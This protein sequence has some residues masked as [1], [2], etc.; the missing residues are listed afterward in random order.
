MSLSGQRCPRAHRRAGAG[1]GVARGNR[2]WLQKRDSNFGSEV[3][4]DS[5][6]AQQHSAHQR[7]KYT[8][9]QRPD[10]SGCTLGLSWW[11]RSQH[12]SEP[13][14]AVQL[15]GLTQQ[16]LQPCSGLAGLGAVLQPRRGC[17]LCAH[18][19][20]AREDE[21]GA[22]CR[23]LQVP[24]PCSVPALMVQ[25]QQVTVSCCSAAAPFQGLPGGQTPCH[26]CHKKT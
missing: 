26:L 16:P 21:P 8:Y 1:S 2:K 13:S 4:R 12:S 3:Q 7:C 11:D 17:G 10:T 9:L 19:G 20:A 22:R 23:S 24:V 18:S 6:A 5:H 14:L 25:H 15:L